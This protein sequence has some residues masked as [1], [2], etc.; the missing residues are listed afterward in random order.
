MSTS[1]KKY[2]LICLSLAALFAG[3]Y[4][5]FK[6]SKTATLPFGRSPKEVLERLIEGN[7]RYATNEF[8]SPDRAS[9]RRMEVSKEQTP[10]AVVVGCSD[11][12][13]PPEIIFDQGL[14]DLFVVRV[15]GQVVGPIE[16]DTI[17]Y[18]LK[19]LGASLVFIL[20]HQSCG[21]V[22]A[23]LDGKTEDIEE[24]ANLIRP[25]IALDKDK[26][27]E[28][29]VKDN[30]HYVVDHLEKTPLIQKM[31]SEGKV[32]VVGGYYQLLDGKVEILH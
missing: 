11:S 6:K 29:A 22:T 7:Q 2:L 12:R 28:Q 31:Q 30:V 32:D 14:G 13:V 26:S 18:G 27:V 24:I 19:Y 21:A 8:E 10:F 20:G 4:F 5:F 17:E 25:A 16:L 1:M 3:A 15:A 9:M 23:V